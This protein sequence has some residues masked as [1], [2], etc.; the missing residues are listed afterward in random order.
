[1]FDDL[2]I[3]AGLGGPIIWLLALLS[4]ISWM[5]IFWKLWELY[6][7]KTFSSKKIAEIQQ[8]TEI[9]T[10]SIQSLPQAV[11]KDRIESE[12]HIIIT[13]KA[14]GLRYLDLIVSIAPLL[15]LFGTVLGMI[16]AFN[17]LE[18]SGSNVDPSRLAGGIWEA[19]LSTAAGMI[20]AIPAAVALTIYEGKLEKIRTEMIS[21]MS[22][23]FNL[24]KIE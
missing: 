1:M 16:D 6:L 20:V 3:V 23:K 17:T 4:L 14:V 11:A 18:Q 12:I 8:F 19:L 5:L 24:N 21:I 2:I 13:E 10:V 7:N 15:G 22:R 9:V